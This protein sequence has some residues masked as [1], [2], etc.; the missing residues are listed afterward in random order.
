MMHGRSALTTSTGAEPPC[1][2]YIS[3]NI[4]AAANFW[5]GYNV[6]GYSNPAYDAACK[7]AQNALDLTQ[8]KQQHALAQKIFSADLPSL[9]LYAEA[10]IAV[11]RPNVTGVFMDPTEN[12]ELWN[13]ENFDISP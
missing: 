8:K 13:V 11:T 5:G 2:L 12:T 1:D 10:K 6:M 7:A 4:S 9:P 3:A